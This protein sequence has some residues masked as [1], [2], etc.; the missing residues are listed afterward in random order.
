MDDPQAKADMQQSLAMCEK[1]LQDVR[2][3][4]PSIER[5]EAQKEVLHQT[6]MT[7]QASVVRLQAAPRP[8]FRGSLRIPVFWVHLRVWTPRLGVNFSQAT[9]HF[10]H[11]VSWF[12]FK[13]GSG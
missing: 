13:Q 7:I 1:R 10:M 11:F 4:A 8:G 6:L 2:A 5:L 12:G 3:L 9:L